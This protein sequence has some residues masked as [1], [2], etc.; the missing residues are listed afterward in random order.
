MAVLPL[1]SDIQRRIWQITKQLELDEILNSFGDKWELVPAGSIVSSPFQTPYEKLR[2]WK[3]RWGSSKT[4]ESLCV[5]RGTKPAWIIKPE[6][7]MNSVT[8]PIG[9]V[10]VSPSLYS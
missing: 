8:L 4:L 5:L 10:T 6:I 1:P 7:F 3:L 2:K 9:G